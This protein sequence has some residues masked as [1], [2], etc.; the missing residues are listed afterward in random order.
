MI[1]GIKQGIMGYFA[2]TCSAFFGSLMG[3]YA[4][5]LSAYYIC[6]RTENVPFLCLPVAHIFL[7]ILA[8]RGIS[9]IEWYRHKSGPFRWSFFLAAVL[10][11]A[12][13]IFL[14]ATWGLTIKGEDGAEIPSFW[15]PL[16]ATT[17]INAE[18]EKYHQ[19]RAKAGGDL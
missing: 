17:R 16:N 10:A 6:Y 12:V 5:F 7:L 14:I 19:S 11:S 13:S 2:P 1:D 15:E 9:S 4:G 3:L 18:S 8:I